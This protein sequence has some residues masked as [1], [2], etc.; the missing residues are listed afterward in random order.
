MEVLTDNLKHT[1]AELL[2]NPETPTTSVFMGYCGY[3]LRDGFELVE[4]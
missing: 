3:T 2:T 1:H 4:D